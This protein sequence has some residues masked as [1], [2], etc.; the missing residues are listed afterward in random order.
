M[1]ARLSLDSLPRETASCFRQLADLDGLRRFYLA[2]SAALALHL[3]HRRPFGL[4]FMSETNSLK[5]PRRRDLMSELVPDNLDVE[6]ETARDG[7]LYVRLDGNVPVRFFHYP[8]ISVDDPCAVIEDHG[9]GVA[10]A[11]LV[12]LGLM[13]LGAIISRGTRHDFVDLYLICRQ[14]PLEHLLETADLKFPRVRDFPLQAFKGL[15][16]RS[17]ADR[18]PMPSLDI[19]L[20]WD[21]ILVWLDRD[22]RDLARRA[23]GLA[24]L[25]S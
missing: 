22:V 24:S 8:Y 17:I 25:G 15:G 9:S 1:A 7:Y 19:A 23:V 21:E 20:A 5:S 13:K 10:V 18:D 14:I 3:G 2:G 4:D 12:D 6:V 11:S 16:D